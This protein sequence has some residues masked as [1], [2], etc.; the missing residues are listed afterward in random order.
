[1]AGYKMSRVQQMEAE[2][3]GMV[4]LIALSFVFRRQ[5]V[6]QDHSSEFD[7]QRVAPHTRRPCS[8]RGSNGGIKKGER[9]GDE[10]LKERLDAKTESCHT[11]ST[12]ERRESEGRECNA[13]E[14]GVKKSQG[15]RIERRE[16][17]KKEG[18]TEG[19][20]EGEEGEEEE[21]GET[22]ERELNGVKKEDGD[23]NG[24]R[25]GSE[26]EG[27]I[28]VSPLEIPDMGD[29]DHPLRDNRAPINVSASEL[30][31][32]VELIADRSV[33]SSIRTEYH[34]EGL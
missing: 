33:S 8:S 6:Y 28:E 5:F 9:A 15:E 2:G 20:E 23:M 22:K 32:K 31:R 26:G 18:S 34:H 24:E 7:R 30:S 14:E 10:R 19:E 17:E 29:D 1:M 21:K 13:E 16:E 27:Q 12:K 3:K 11:E 25:E 4:I